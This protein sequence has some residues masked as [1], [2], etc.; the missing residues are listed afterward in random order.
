MRHAAEE[1]ARVVPDGARF[2]TARDFPSEIGRTGMIE[3]PFWL[4]RVS[5]RDT[6]NGFNL[7]A[8]ST[9]V[10]L[11]GVDALSKGAPEEAANRLARLGVTHVVTTSDAQVTRLTGSGRFAVVWQEEPMAVLAVVAP[12]GE[13]QPSSLLSADVPLDGA[14]TDANPEHLR[15]DAAP[16]QPASVTVAVAWS[17]KWSASVDG[18]SAPITRTTDGL[19]AVQLPAGHSAIELRYGRD[20]WDTLGFAAT[21][22]SLAAIAAWWW[23]R[24]QPAGASVS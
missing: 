22:V 24:R 16:A 2:A 18:R 19:I 14:L 23:R 12:P 5:G 1:L 8:T 7:E 20:G 9:A 6:I 17:P 3:P 15:F 13:P 4:A 11:G 21:V 10:A